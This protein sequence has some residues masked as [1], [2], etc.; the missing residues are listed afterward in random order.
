MK[1]G[2]LVA[3]VLALLVGAALVWLVRPMEAPTQKAGVSAEPSQ[4]AAAQTP[5]TT[6]P[7]QAPAPSPANNTSTR[8]NAPSGNTQVRLQLVE[9]QTKL[10]QQIE[11]AFALVAQT[12]AE[13]YVEGWQ[14]EDGEVQWDSAVP[15]EPRLMRVEPIGSAEQVPADP[16]GKGGERVDTRTRV[17]ALVLTPQL[18]PEVFQLQREVDALRARL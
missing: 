15:G 2:C 12:K 6:V 18:A 17:R 8:T 5:D 3:A 9:L 7:V 16:N 13:G 10:A 14:A 4:P 11:D 1:Q